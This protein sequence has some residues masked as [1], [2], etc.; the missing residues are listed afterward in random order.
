MSIK[1][2]VDNDNIYMVIPKPINSYVN[3]IHNVAC[4]LTNNEHIDDSF[5][6]NCNIDPVWVNNLSL[7]KNK[8][9]FD[10]IILK[11][12]VYYMKGFKM[13]G[14]NIYHP[15]FDSEWLFSVFLQIKDYLNIP[16]TLQT[17]LV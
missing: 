13:C 16:V 11:D 15:E 17:M 1:F 8:I 9:L 6:N 2:L 5:F 4:K 10:H 3:I 7:N 12:G 14:L